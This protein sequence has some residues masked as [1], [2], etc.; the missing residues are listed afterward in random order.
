[1]AESKEPQYEVKTR[2]YRE[3]FNSREEAE[4]QYDILRKR[5][6]KKDESVKVELSE[7]DPATSRKTPI[8]NL[9]LNENFNG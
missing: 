9:S 5:S 6:I 8:K 3:T 2:G 1:M 4:K 7:V